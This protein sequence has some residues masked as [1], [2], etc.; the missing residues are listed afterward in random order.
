MAPQARIGGRGTQQRQRRSE[1]TVL[2]TMKALDGFTIRATDGDIGTVTEGYFDDLSYAVRHIVVDTGGWLGDRKVLI[3]PIAVRA[4]DWEHKRIAVALTKAQVEKSPSIDTDK[5]VSRQHEVA[6]YDYYGYTPY[7]TGPYLWGAYP[8]PYAE[9]GPS[10]E[11]A[12]LELEP[13]WDWESRERDDPHLR[14]SRAVTG[15]HIEAT[16]GGIGHVE[17][18][19]VDDVAWAIRY[20][21]VDTTNWWA[22]KKVLVAPAWIQRVDWAESKVHVALTRALIRTSPDYDPTRPVERAYETQLCGHYGR[23]RYWRE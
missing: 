22:G 8:Y 3:S 1:D 10:L 23:P 4:T 15:Y 9:A 7:W 2:G 16:D 6:Y 14:S 19:L 5:P 18:F 21:I 17:D 13:R 20:M 11:K 12:D